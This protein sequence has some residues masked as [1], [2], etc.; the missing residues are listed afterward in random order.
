MTGAGPGT[1]AAAGGKL[2]DRG[3]AGPRRRWRRT[4]QAMA[5]PR[6]DSCPA[7]PVFL[8]TVTKL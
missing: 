5:R 2:P 4:V 8:K 1:T 7:A 3:G 6:L